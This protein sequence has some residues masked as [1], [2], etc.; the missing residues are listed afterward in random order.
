LALGHPP[1]AEIE[2]EIRKD[3]VKLKRETMGEQ[4]YLSI[5]D[6]IFRLNLLQHWPQSSPKNMS[7]P[8]QPPTLEVNSRRSKDKIGRD[9]DGKV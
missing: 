7:F 1:A 6:L 5:R 3:S 2:N 8:H 4:Q 9:R